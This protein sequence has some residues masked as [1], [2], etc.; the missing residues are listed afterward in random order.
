MIETSPNIEYI[1]EWQPANRATSST[2]KSSNNTT[3]ADKNNPAK[4]GNNTLSQTAIQTIASQTNNIKQ[5][6]SNRI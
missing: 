5:L 3:A 2:N 1:N 6:N 4:A